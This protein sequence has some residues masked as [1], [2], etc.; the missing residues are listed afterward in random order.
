VEIVKNI[1]NLRRAVLA[2]LLACAPLL[3][4]ATSDPLERLITTPG[5]A[6]LG[7]AW[8]LE[9]S[10]YRG[11]SARYDFLPL[12]MYEGTHGYL[13]SSRAGLKLT[14]PR[15]GLRLDA[16]LSHRFEGFPHERVPLEMQGLARRE[17][18]VDAGLG[19]QWS[20][21]LGA[22]YVEWLHD[23]SRSSAGR[24]LRLG[25]RT[26][27]T[28]GRLRAWPHAMLSLREARLNDYYY[29][30]RPDEAAAFRPA[31]AAG[32]GVNGQLGLFAAYSLTERWRLLG[33]LVATQ[34]SSSVRRS[35]LVEDRTQLA[36]TLGF[37]YDFSPEQEAWPEGRPLI[38]RAYYGASSDCDVAK[39]IR[40]VCTTTHTQDS[41]SIAGLDV[42]RPFVGR[43]NGWPLDLA[44]FV[45][46]I[47]HKERGFQTDFWQVRAYIKAYYYGFPWDASVRTRLGMGVGL[48]YARRIPLMEVRDQALRGRVTSKVLT[49]LDPTVDVSLGDLIRVRR[50]QDTFVGLG[51][52]H[53]SGIF[54]TSQLLGN[55]DGGSNYIYG[56]VEVS[57]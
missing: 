46:V 30:V 15:R 29:G 36:A 38:A 34:W 42:G 53:R 32:G 4:G 12:V 5:G 2:S 37:L 3:A 16:F 57:F 10:P 19:L 54:G 50:L 6:G 51:V 25:A 35:P 9:R 47:R 18:G 41:T 43:L 20:S 17:P 49:Y 45:G 31:Y 33:G 11:V 26:E 7:A 8:R 39:I 48:S 24:E 13:H 21:P 1:R 28:R 44:G 40:L 27:W 14:D 22:L 55:V 23:V 52:S 56:Y